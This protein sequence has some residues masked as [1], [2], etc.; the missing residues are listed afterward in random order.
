L[1]P[2]S[3]LETIKAVFTTIS[4]SVKSFRSKR[5][6]KII[7]DFLEEFRKVIIKLDSV[8]KQHMESF[9]NLLNGILQTINAV[10]VSN[11][12]N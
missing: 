9:L 8:P 5:C 6:R 10:L 11:L 7:E 2:D 4:E 1:D 12:C 3:V